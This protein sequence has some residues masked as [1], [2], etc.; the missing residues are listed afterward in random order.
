MYL[1]RAGHF[2]SIDD[3]PHISRKVHPVVHDG[4][5]LMKL[6]AGKEIASFGRMLGEKLI[7]KTISR[8][9]MFSP[10]RM[11]QKFQLRTSVDDETEHRFKG[12]FYNK[13]FFKII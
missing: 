3:Y 8:T 12:T 7:D 10:R 5:D 1:A 13:I 9:K 6:Y 4:F 2:Q 11:S